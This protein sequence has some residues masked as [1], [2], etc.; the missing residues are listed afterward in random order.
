MFCSL[1]H[2]SLIGHAKNTLLGA[3]PC[4]EARFFADEMSDDDDVDM[5]AF[6][7]LLVPAPPTSAPVTHKANHLLPLSL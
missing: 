2:G 6:R 1:K 4:D 5:E 7:A 3:R